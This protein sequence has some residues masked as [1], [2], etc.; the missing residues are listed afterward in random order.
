MLQ[1]VIDPN[2]PTVWSSPTLSAPISSLVA[3]LWR[4]TDS[5]HRPGVCLM[6]LVLGMP[7]V[8]AAAFFP[9]P[10]EDLREQINWGS[11]FLLHTSKHPPLQTW[12]AQ[13][14]ALTGARDAWAYVLLAQLLNLAGIVYAVKIARE[15][16]D[17]RLGWPVA[18]ALCGNL[19]ISVEAL[20]TALN[21]DQILGPL[22][23]AVLYHALRAARD[24]RWHD[25]VA[26]AGFGGLALLAKYFS[27][28][29]LLALAIALVMHRPVLLRSFKPYEATFLCL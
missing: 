14:V 24:D 17:A 19:L 15:F 18:I 7:V 26:C 16:I 23:L 13:L 21:A 9:T 12:L 11:T 3:S 6:A 20:T 10:S 8:F 5:A 1:R 2:T 29:Y 22:W 4:G 28:A 27:A 25:W